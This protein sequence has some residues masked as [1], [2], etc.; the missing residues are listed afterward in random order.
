MS[1][2]PRTLGELRRAGYE[3]KT[4]REEI[5]ANLVRKLEAGEPLSR[6]IVGYQDTAVP[7]IT[8]ALLAAQNVTVL[9]ERGQAKS[10]LIR[11]MIGLLDP[12][13]P[14]VAGSELNDSPYAPVSLKA[15]RRLAEP[16]DDLAIDWLPRDAR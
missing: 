12:E 7:E 14:V 6:G 11:A 2:K 10:R 16:G 3:P 4:V 15:R 13:I 8:H 1:T 5:H 9:S